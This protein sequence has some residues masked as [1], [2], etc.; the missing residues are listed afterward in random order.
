MSQ[1]LAFA[2]SYQDRDILDSPSLGE[3]AGL[4]SW[5]SGTYAERI[6]PGAPV[7]AEE[8]LISDARA[9]LSPAQ[10]VERKLMG[11]LK[12]R[13]LPVSQLMTQTAG[14]YRK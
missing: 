14:R 10:M 9:S 11:L 4:R 6:M 13:P 1:Q 8:A 3:D 5:P 2:P 7:V 12:S